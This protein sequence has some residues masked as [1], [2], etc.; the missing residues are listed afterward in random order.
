VHGWE[1]TQRQTCKS[2]PIWLLQAFEDSQGR[3]DEELAARTARELALRE[4]EQARRA[5][6]AEAARYEPTDCI[7]CLV[8]DQWIAEAVRP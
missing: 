2:H 8:V 7:S 6:E 5:A 4:E 1:V 3:L